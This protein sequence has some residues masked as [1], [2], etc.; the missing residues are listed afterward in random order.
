MFARI[1]LLQHAD[2]DRK[3]CLIKEKILRKGTFATLRPIAKAA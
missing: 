2:A 1:G 3:V